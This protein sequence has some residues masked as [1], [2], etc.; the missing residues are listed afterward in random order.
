MKNKAILFLSIAFAAVLGFSSCSKDENQ[1]PKIKS[2]ELSSDNKTINVTFSEVVY[3]KADMTGALDASS[4][5]VTAPASVDFTY[6]VSHTAGSATATINLTITSIL[7]GT[8]KFT[9]K[10]ASATSIYDNEGKAMEAAEMIESN[11]AAQDLGIM[12]SWVSEGSNV[13]PL[14]VTYFN[15]LKVEAEFKADF[16]YVVN[17]FNIGNATTTPDLVFTGTYEIVKSTFGN[18]WTITCSQEL[19]YTAT[20]SG[21]F[22]IKTGPEV[23]W[24]EVVQTSGTQNVPPTPALGFGSSNGGTL[25]ELNIQKFVRVQ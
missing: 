6:T 14:L 9:V 20:A 3:A 22:E 23:L 11:A 25:G 18:I 10:P 21:I 19:P 16:T 17:Q 2:A 15:V 1:A 24:Y 4:L 13:A 8:E 7:Q 5:T 12:G